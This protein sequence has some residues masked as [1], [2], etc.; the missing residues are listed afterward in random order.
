MPSRSRPPIPI[1]VQVRVLYRD[2]WLCSLCGRPTIFHLALKYLDEFVHANGYDGPTAYFQI[3]GDGTLRRFWMS[4]G[5]LILPLHFAQATAK[6]S[7]ACLPPL[8]KAST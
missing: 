1:D 4:L 3:D 6:L 2:G 5:V 7:S 8:E